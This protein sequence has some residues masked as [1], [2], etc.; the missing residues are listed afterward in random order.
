MVK[1]SIALVKAAVIFLL[2]GSQPN[3]LA[4][5]VELTLGAIGVTED[6][7]CSRPHPARKIKRPS[8]NAIPRVRDHILLG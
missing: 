7:S 1:G 8:S 6:A 5:L 2:M 3:K 4:G